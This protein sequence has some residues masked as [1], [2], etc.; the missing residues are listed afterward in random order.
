MEDCEDRNM[1]KSEWDVKE[2]E[3][4]FT[5]KLRAELSE[6]AVNKKS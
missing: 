2:A 6:F 1:W 4:D 5:K 3:D